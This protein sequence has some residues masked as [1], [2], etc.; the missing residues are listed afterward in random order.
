MVAVLLL[1]AA[2]PE[3]LHV[4][5]RAISS[6]RPRPVP[7]H[8]RGLGR[9]NH[10]GCVTYPRSVVERDRIVSRVSRHPC[11]LIVD[12]LNQIDASGRVIDR[13]FG[14]RLSDDHARSINSK[15][16]LLPASVAAAPVF[17]GSPFAFAHN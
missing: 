1:P 4:R 5:D 9:W 2:P 3:R 10:D 8:L 7:R 17:H 13:R 12:R 14:Q 11:D 15:M 6:V 16:Q